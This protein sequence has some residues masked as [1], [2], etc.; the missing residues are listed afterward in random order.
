MLNQSF[1]EEN[2]KKIIEIQNRKGIYL[3]G[4][5]FPEIAKISQDIKGLNN[6]LRTLKTRRLSPIQLEKQ[7][8]KLND[9]KE[10]LKLK[11]ENTLNKKLI[12]IS[13]KV[14]DNKFKI[15]IVKDTAI[16][17]KPV[18]KLVYNLEN[19]LTLKQLQYNFR[20]LYKVKQSNRYAIISQL[21]NLL[22][23]GFPKIILKT[24]IKEFYENINQE[25]LLKK[26]TD[27]N[28]LTHL[29]RKFIKQ[30]LIH[31]NSLTGSQKGVPRGVGI[32]AYLAELYMRDFDKQIRALPQVIYYSRYV[33]DII[34]IF[35]PPGDNRPITY[36]ERI[37]ELMEKEGLTMNED[38]EKTKEINISNKKPDKLYNFDYLGYSFSS[39]YINKKHVPLRVSISKRKK[40]RYAKRLLK[41]FYLYM[42]NSKRNEKKARKLLIKRLRFLT[43]NTRLVNNK[44]NI[45]TGIYY[46][47][48]LINTLDDLALLDRYFRYLLYKFNL[49]VHLE[50]R[51]SSNF[52]FESGFSPSKLKKFT[53]TE[54]KNLINGWAR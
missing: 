12:I 1:S 49:P 2:F 23:D 35:L 24:D 28:L 43:N 4:D 41:A 22:D 7:K 29:S 14:T 37:K 26:L 51:I 54:L 16:T 50:S 52:S 42:N 21:K 38:P 47:N 45:L 13:K 33:D 18:Y 30:I 20:K 34:I 36:L 8:K 53:S 15:G 3:E 6:Q 5:F 32:S 40:K 44:K 39:G 11:K 48:N 17:S 31:F 19:I 25:K 27:D 9:K 10:K 46:S